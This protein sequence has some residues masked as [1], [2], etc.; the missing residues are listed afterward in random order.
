[1]NAKRYGLA[2]WIVLWIVALGWLLSLAP[3][4]GL[5]VLFCVL[6]IFSCFPV[7]HAVDYIAM[8]LGWGGDS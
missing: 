7:F 4:T 6:G 2:V 3:P 8:I 5:F 1:M